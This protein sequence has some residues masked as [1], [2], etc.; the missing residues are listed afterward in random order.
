MELFWKA[1][2]VSLLTA[3]LGVVMGK[4]SK[5]IS[6]LL[7]I[8]GCVLIAGLTAVYLSPVVGFMKE[9]ESLGN[10][11]GDMLGILLKAVGIGLISEIASV[12][13]G[14]SGNAGLGKMIQL[15]GS[16]VI[17]WLSIP[18]FRVLMDL[19]QTILGEL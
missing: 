18:V 4:Q 17:L 3:I 7:S 6:L 14:D 1:I 15:I 9:L 19:V 5:D 11:R 8:A 10:L 12:V 13:S 16:V 2:A